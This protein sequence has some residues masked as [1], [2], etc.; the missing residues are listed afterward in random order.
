MV[1]TAILDIALTS[2][3]VPIANWLKPLNPNQPNQS[4]NVPN[5]TNGILDAAK[6]CIDFFSPLLPNLPSLAPKTITPASAAAPP[7]P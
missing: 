4:K 7:H 1:L 2:S 5:V 6:G 3:N